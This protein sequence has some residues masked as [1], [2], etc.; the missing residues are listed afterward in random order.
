MKMKEIHDLALASYLVT[1]G[2]KILSFKPE[3]NKVIFVFEDSNNLEADIL[4]FINRRASVDP[5]SFA[6][7]M[8]NLKALVLRS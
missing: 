2:H 3:R 7:Q 8:R 4:S 1:I 6:E 5:L